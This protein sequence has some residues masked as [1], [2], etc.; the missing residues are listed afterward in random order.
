MKEQTATKKAS[1]L[2][3]NY[4]MLKSTLAVKEDVDIS[5]F[6]KLIAYLKRQNSGY[7]PKKS[8]V[9]SREEV[10]KFINEAPNSIILFNVLWLMYILA[11]KL[12]YRWPRC[13]NGSSARL[14]ARVLAGFVSLGFYDVRLFGGLILES[15]K[16]VSSYLWTGSWS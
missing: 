14:M 9:S 7:K 4:S 2:W 16:F 12:W 6:S 1:T 5:K 10:S 3:A 15:T 11:I 13:I 8:A